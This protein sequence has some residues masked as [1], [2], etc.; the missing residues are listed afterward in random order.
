MMHQKLL[1][2]IES[3]GYDNAAVCAVINIGSV[4]EDFFEVYKTHEPDALL[5]FLEK[6]TPLLLDLRK[7]K[8]LFI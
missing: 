2:I 8:A 3:N 6:L 7:G 5:E 1:K 4:L